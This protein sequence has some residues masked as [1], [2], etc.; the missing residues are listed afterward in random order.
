MALALALPSVASWSQSVSMSGSL[1]SKALLVIDGAPRTVAVGST[2]NGVK[3]ISVTGSETVVEFGGRRQTL[4]LGG[5]QVNLGGT[6]SAGGGTQ[7]VIPVG[8]GGHFVT[9]GSINDRAVRFVVDT[10][11]TSISMGE[12]E[13][14]RIG[15]DYTHGLRGTVQTAN[16]NAPAYKLAL[17]SVRIGDVTVYNVDAVVLPTGMDVILLG[18]SFLSRFQMRRDNDMLVLEKRF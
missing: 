3:V 14:R 1:G 7:I 5:A 12:A 6:A 16:G 9:E 10:G 18:N 11:A 8:S 17:G 15:L 4:L 2:V 13:A